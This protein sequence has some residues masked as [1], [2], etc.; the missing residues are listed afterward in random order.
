MRTMTKKDNIFSCSWFMITR[1]SDKKYFDKSSYIFDTIL[2]RFDSDLSHPR[3]RDMGTKRGV[4]RGV[5]QY[6]D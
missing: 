1:P 3:L 6:V 5:E 4:Y 2:R